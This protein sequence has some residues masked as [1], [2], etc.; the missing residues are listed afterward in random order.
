M[1]TLA[2]VSAFVEL[3]VFSR[4]RTE[5]NKD[6]CGEKKNA[7][8]AVIMRRYLIRL[9]KRNWNAPHE[10][11]PRDNLAFFHR[12]VYRQAVIF[13]GVIIELG[14]IAMKS[15]TLVIEIKLYQILLGHASQNYSSVF[16][17]TQFVHL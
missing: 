16:Q 8:H 7:K 1:I 14:A 3:F 13:H 6:K 12:V 5:M 17:S 11:S 15:N 10:S 4:N 9:G 2:N